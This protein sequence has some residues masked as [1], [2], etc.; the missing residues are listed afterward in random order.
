M[1]LASLNTMLR[2]FYIN[3]EVGNVLWFHDTCDASRFRFNNVSYGAL[4]NGFIKS[5]YVKFD[6]VWLKKTDDFVDTPDLIMYNIVLY[7]LTRDSEAVGDGFMIYSKMLQNHIRP[8][9]YTYNSLAYGLCLQFKVEEADR[10]LK[11]VES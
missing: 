11:L 8:D 7:G 6:V 10:F 2:G 5:G 3:D 4:L 1:K 9:I